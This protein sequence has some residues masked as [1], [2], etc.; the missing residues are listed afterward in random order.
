MAFCDIAE[1][2]TVHR[3]GSD[4]GGGRYDESSATLA[5]GA[6]NLVVEVRTLE[7]DGECDEQSLQSHVSCGLADAEQACQVFREASQHETDVRCSC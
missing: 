6:A 1:Q 7:K 5:E 3:A 2:G 4:V